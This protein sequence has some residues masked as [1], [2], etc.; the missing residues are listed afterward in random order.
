MAKVTWGGN[1]SADAIDN[2]ER[3]NFKPY[4]GPMPVPGMYAWKINI[5]RRRMSSNN[6][7]QLMVG[8]ELIPRKTRPDDQK[9]KGYFI[10]DF[11][12]VGESSA[13]R[14]APFLDAIGVKG[15]D[16]IDRTKDDGTDKGNIVSIG[17]WK[18]TGKQYVQASLVM[19]S[20]NG[21]PRLEIGGYWPPPNAA[22]VEPEPEP[23]EDEDEEVTDT[24]GSDYDE[25]PPF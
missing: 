19:G 5:L 12:P 23:D 24:A 14:L 9:Y 8:L 11:I 18:H 17:K 3:G 15:S 13:F 4:D 25:E 22:P 16:F 20:Y 2:A 1:V 7:P 21:A 6:N 10:T